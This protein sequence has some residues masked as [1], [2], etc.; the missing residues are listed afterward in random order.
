MY[1]VFTTKVSEVKQQEESFLCSVIVLALN[2]LMSAWK[3]LLGEN[4]R[5]FFVSFL[6]ICYYH[7]VPH[8]M[9]LYISNKC[10]YVH[11][12]ILTEKNSLM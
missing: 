10:I 5:S 3:E 2:K 4:F 12:I 11:K 1:P 8:D 7:E 9:F 6:L